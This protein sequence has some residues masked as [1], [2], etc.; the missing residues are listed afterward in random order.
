[1][2]I[3]ALPLDITKESPDYPALCVAN[4][5]LGGGFL[6]SRLANRIRNQDGLSY[7]VGSRLLVDEKDNFGKFTVYAICAPQNIE[8]VDKAFKEEIARALKDGFSA[9]ELKKAKQGIS[10][11]Y[12]VGRAMDT[13]VVSTL[14]ENLYYHHNF[15]E[16]AQ[17]EQKIMAV[18]PQQVLEVLRRYVDVEKFTV[19]KAGDFNRTEK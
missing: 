7:G 8:K 13:S 15:T 14:R 5:L 16:N 11:V 9:D 6:D 3:A 12:K 19:I 2:F 17:L 1:M 4:Y 18:T 10:Q